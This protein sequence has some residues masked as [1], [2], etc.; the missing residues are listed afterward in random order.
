MSMTCIA[1]NDNFEIRSNISRL[2]HA[3]VGDNV[4]NKPN[5]TAED[6]AFLQ[7]CGVVVNMT[8]ISHYH[9]G[10]DEY[11]GRDCLQED[12]K[13]YISTPSN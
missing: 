8:L 4:R 7:A 3:G 11:K 12:I 6:V 5:V 2:P 1:V 10:T 13:K 9:K